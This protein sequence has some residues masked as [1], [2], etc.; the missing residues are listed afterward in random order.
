MHTAKKEFHPVLILAIAAIAISTLTRLALLV[1]TGSGFDYSLKNIAGA[2]VIGLLYDLVV[3]S[4]LMIPL[5]LHIWFRTDAIY[6]RKFRPV[7]IVIFITILCIILFTRLI[8]AE[9]NE[10]L[11]KFVIYY[12]IARFIIYLLFCFLSPVARNKWR[13][14]VLYLDLFIF[15]FLL[16]LNAVSEWFFWQEFS[17]RYNFIAVDY[18]IYTNEVI[19][20]IRESYPLNWILFGIG[21]VAGLGV[22][23]VRKA[24][25]ESVQTKNSF[26]RKSLIALGLF[27]ISF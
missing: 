25:K 7:M 14:A 24:I 5:V 26:P 20:N 9:F 23:L 10:D 13:V 11:R 19:G 21:L 27:C 12:F 4:F 3:A 15:F 17:V 22:F 6:N 8:P 16:L 1:Q 2:F 18:L